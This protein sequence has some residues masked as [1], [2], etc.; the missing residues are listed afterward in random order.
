MRH[1]LLISAVAM[2][3]AAL[4]LATSF[5]PAK[6][7]AFCQPYWQFTLTL[8]TRFQERL[9]WSLDLP[10]DGGIKRSTELWQ[11]HLNGTWSLIGVAEAPGRIKEACG[12]VT[13]TERPKT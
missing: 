11:N 5:E 4:T 6:A 8:Q 10:D 12:L 7:A 9:Q 2:P 13:G 1:A 3:V